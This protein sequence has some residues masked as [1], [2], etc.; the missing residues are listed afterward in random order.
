MVNMFSAEEMCNGFS[1][2]SDPETIKHLLPC[3]SLL[4]LGLFDI[5]EEKCYK[6][7][8]H[9]CA[10]AGVIGILSGTFL[11]V[12]STVNDKLSWL[13]MCHRSRIQDKIAQQF[14][15]LCFNTLNEFSEE[16]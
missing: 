12:I 1:G 3:N 9:E 6:F 7:D 15:N 2:S 4:S 14:A 13:I 10:V 8:V 5:G 11:H 16:R